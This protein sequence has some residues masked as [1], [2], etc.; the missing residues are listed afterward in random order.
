MV[1]CAL[2]AGL[3]LSAGSAVAQLD[4]NSVTVTASRNAAAQADVAN[5]AVYVV[6]GIDVSLADVLAA[7][8][9]SPITAANFT[10]IGG[11]GLLSLNVFPT[12]AVPLP[13]QI[14]WSFAL[15]VP[16]SKIKDT[17]GG[18]GEV[19]R[20]DIDPAKSSL[21]PKKIDAVLGLPPGD[22]KDGVY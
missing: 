20:V 2:V 3:V 17:A 5:F 1:K 8:Q 6:S 7:L 18:K 12:P 22:F 19:P 21:D 13:P 15:S 4:S 10:G 14:Q 9:G 16:I 11:S